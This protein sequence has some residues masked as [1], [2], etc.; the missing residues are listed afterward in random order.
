MM[1]SPF[2]LAFEP[3]FEPLAD[4]KPL[5]LRL[6]ALLLMPP[7]VVLAV[8]APSSHAHGRSTRPAEGFGAVLPAPAAPRIADGSI[9]DVSAGYTALAEGRRAH[10]VGDSLTILLTEQINSS[11]SAGSKTQ[12]TGA[13]NVVPPTGGPF[14]F[15]DPN[16][17]KASGGSSFNGQGNASQTSTLG[18][19]VSVTI[20]E[21]RANGTALVK[22]EKRLLLSQG[23][24]W[25]QVSG[26]VR[27][28]DIDADNRVR[29][30]QVADARVTYTGNGTIGRSSREGW[31]SKFF[32][33]ITPF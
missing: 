31:L 19:E 24:E 5:G 29:S 6:L 4:S 23:Q 14:A 25:V 1:D 13:F 10:M 2:D 17:L 26:I 12:K 33:M 15:L 32:N 21:V 20:A 18:G 9:F 3:V 7:A 28:G 27:L 30:T 8:L 22:G 16:A 11:K